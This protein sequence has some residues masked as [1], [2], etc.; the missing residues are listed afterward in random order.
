MKNT[1]KSRSS[2][3]IIRDVSNALGF[4]PTFHDSFP[5]NQAKGTQNRAVKWFPAKTR[6][7]NIEKAK[8]MI[9]KKYPKARVKFMGCWDV[10]K[11]NQFTVYF[12]TKWEKK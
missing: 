1:Y 12:T 10:Y 3:P 5:P 7:A 4:A 6:K 11:G 9:A 8:K 2:F